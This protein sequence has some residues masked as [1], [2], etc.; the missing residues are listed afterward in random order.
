VPTVSQSKEQRRRSFRWTTFV[1][2]ARIPVWCLRLLGGFLFGDVYL[3]L[4]D[5]LRGP[6]VYERVGSV[7]LNHMN[8]E[9]TKQSLPSLWNAAAEKELILV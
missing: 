4:V 9:A 1:N 3:V 5:S 8:A 2:E 7:Y 6:H